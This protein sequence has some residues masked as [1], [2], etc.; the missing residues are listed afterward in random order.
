MLTNY[1]SVR[2]YIGERARGVN[3]VCVRHG[4]SLTRGCLCVNR[5]RDMRAGRNRFYLVLCGSGSFSNVPVDYC[6]RGIFI[7]MLYRG[8]CGKYVTSRV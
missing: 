8:A 2:L 1:G 4:R 3:G 6:A 7:E 5:W